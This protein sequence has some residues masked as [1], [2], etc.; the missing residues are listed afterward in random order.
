MRL[1]PQPLTRFAALR[2]PHITHHVVTFGAS[3][4]LP[5]FEDLI[6]RFANCPDLGTFSRNEAER[7]SDPSMSS[8]KAPEAA[9]PSLRHWL[10]FLVVDGGEQRG[11]G[12]D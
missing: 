10:P 9:G 4:A 7:T 12:A 1:S 11:V 6:L 3:A 8:S 5:G 2:I